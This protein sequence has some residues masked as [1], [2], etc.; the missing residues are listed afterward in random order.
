MFLSRAQRAKGEQE[1][2]A[3][4]RARLLFPNAAAFPPFFL[5]LLLEVVFEMKKKL[6]TQKIRAF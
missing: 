1:E 2:G 6:S 5:F 4:P 3:D